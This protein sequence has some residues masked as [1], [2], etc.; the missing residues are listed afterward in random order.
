M[1]PD[2]QLS[3]KLYQEKLL[4]NFTKS[5]FL[6]KVTKTQPNPKEIDLHRTLEDE[7]ILN[8]QIEGMIMK[9]IQT[10]SPSKKQK[11][12]QD[13]SQK[14]NL[15]REKQNTKPTYYKR[16]AEIMSANDFVTQIH[17]MPAKIF[18][19][20][21]DFKNEFEKKVD[22]LNDLFKDSMSSYHQQK[23]RNK[24]YQTPEKSKSLFRNE[25]LSNVLSQ[26]SQSITQNQQAKRFKKLADSIP[27][28]H[29]TVN[30]SINQL[31]TSQSQSSLKP[32][33]KQRA[34]SAHKK[35]D[36]QRAQ[37]AHNEKKYYN[38]PISEDNNAPSNITENPKASSHYD[39][40]KRFYR[41]QDLDKLLAKSLTIAERAD[42][43]E[44]ERNKLLKGALRTSS[45]LN[46]HMDTV[47]RTIERG[48][49]TVNT[50]KINQPVMNVELAEKFKE[51][52]LR[53][54]N[55]LKI[56]TRKI[57]DDKVNSIDKMLLIS[58]GTL[59]FRSPVIARPQTAK[60]S[61]KD[62]KIGRKIELRSKVMKKSRIL[63]MS[64]EH[65]AL[66]K[67]SRVA[68]MG[69]TPGRDMSYVNYYL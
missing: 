37:S 3:L 21:L 31:P 6:N 11:A 49:N 46:Y 59:K 18:N 4:K 30:L 35:A 63:E 28:P 20:T 65:S 54:L 48:K 39:F 16:E 12:I 5:S 58:S 47:L 45:N 40:K 69:E 43:R 55:Q 44:Y 66:A 17:Q 61:D 9:R 42:F 51:R 10:L 34:Q 22:K 67:K 19:E 26:T 38:N 2:Q 15:R 7:K 41:M 29:K 1:Q 68:L 62:K 13:L 60:N 8:G 53:N 64:W 33:E 50:P 57:I 52:M 25:V 56:N 24:S 27:Q 32:E 23:S 36:K 14:F